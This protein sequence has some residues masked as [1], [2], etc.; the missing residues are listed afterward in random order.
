M[1]WT[2][3][4]TID[5]LLWLFVASSVAYVFFFSIIAALKEKDKPLQNQGNFNHPRNKFLVLI[6]AYKE[7]EVI[8]DTVDVFLRQTY[9]FDDFR[10]AVISDSM[11]EETND[12]LRTLPITLF[13]PHFTTSSKAKSLQ[14]A[15]N[16]IEEEYD[17]IIILDADN[18][19]EDNFLSIL[20][21]I[22]NEKNYTA[23]QCH[24]KAKNMNNEIAQLDGISEEINNSIFRR[25]HNRIGLSSALIGSGMC[26]QFQWFKDNVKK[27]T[28]AGE[29]RELEI[30]LAQQK[31]YVKYLEN[32]YVYDEKVSNKE[33]FQRQRLRWMTVQV[34]CLHY[35]LPLLGH[36]IKTR[37]IILIDKT[38]QQALIPRSML[39]AITFLMA[40]LTT[41]C[42][43]VWTLKWWLLFTIVILSL[44]M[45]TPPMMRHQSIWG[46]IIRFPSLVFNMTANIRNI[47]K[48]SKD[49][50][51]TKHGEHK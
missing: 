29:D 35:L 43:S 8:G 31:K 49:F 4:H 32:L 30:L 18:I 5:I 9:P 15:I 7:D 47:D 1:I 17:Y 26:F 39:V 20:N 27:L 36:A 45:S 23:I 14:Y 2:I 50:I 22:C 13:N 34:Q 44:Y 16:N 25:A 37:N 28:T 51:H 6:P 40:V 41:C 19:V 42:V 46:K 33:N 21:R 38:I 24:R 12:Y 10:I 48:N 11:K 3:I